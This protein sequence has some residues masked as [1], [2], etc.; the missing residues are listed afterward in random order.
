MGGRIFGRWTAVRAA[1]LAAAIVVSLAVGV[2]G[3]RPASAANGLEPRLDC[4]DYDRANNLLIAHWGYTNVNGVPITPAPSENFF[5]PPPFF[6]GQPET[7]QPGV[8]RDVFQTPFPAVG[9]D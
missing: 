3:S 8:H 6:R 1:S 4:V 5:D 9:A 2:V 7:F